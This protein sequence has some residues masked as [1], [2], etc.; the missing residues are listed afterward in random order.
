MNTTTTNNLITLA[1]WMAGDFSNGQQSIDNPQLFA[2][3]HVFFRPLPFS[4]FNA[5]GFYSEQVYDYDLWSPYRQGIHRVVDRG[6]D[7]YIENYG[8]QDSIR[9][10]G[11]GR[12]LSILNTITTDAIE[13]RHNC[14]MVF[15]RQDDTFYGNV[16]GTECLIDRQGCSTYL[17]SEVEVTATTFLSLDRGMDLTTHAQMWGSTNGPLKFAKIQDFSSE[18]QI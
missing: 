4:F 10:A 1:Q 7:I 6:E 8:L 5:I 13:R 12:E 9:Y 17:V 2:H 11:A 3:I 15:K 14:S 18:I 16:E